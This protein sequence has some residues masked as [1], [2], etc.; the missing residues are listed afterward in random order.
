MQAILVKTPGGPEQLQLGEYPKPEPKPH[1]LLLKV[2]ATAL[3]RA[4]TLQ[5]Q[6]KYPPPA[7]ASPLLGLE[8][9]GVV[10]AAGAECK[11]FKPG[12]KVFGLLPGGGYA[13]YAVI[14]EAMAMSVPENLSMEEAAAIPEVFL[15]AFQA[16]VWLGR[17]QAGERVL[18]HAGASGVGTAAIQLAKAMGAEVLVTASA[19]KHQVCLELGAD[20]AIDYKNTSF[21]EEVL[22]Y[23][24]NEGVDVIVDF[25][26]GPYFSDNLDCLRTDGRLVMLATLGGGKVEN[27]DV[28]KILAKRLQITGSTLRSR[29]R[30]YQVHLTQE[31]SDFAVEKFKSGELKPVIDSVY[32][33]QEVAEAHRHMEANKNTGKIVL[34]VL[35]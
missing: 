27:L 6:G 22:A 26:S 4:D 35:K 16:L 14:D 5:R 24:K 25:I 8:V 29:S 32:D 19:E 18:I 1:E 30:A 33:W 3:N 10:E 2:H 9:A 13:A 34:Q 7:G 17:L 12:N 15:T 11:T 28:R 20:K 21:K 23:T 31:L